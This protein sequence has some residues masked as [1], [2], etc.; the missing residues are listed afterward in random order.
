MN[1]FGAKFVCKPVQL[2]EL[3]KWPNQ[4]NV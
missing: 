2:H 3:P 4:I 1:I